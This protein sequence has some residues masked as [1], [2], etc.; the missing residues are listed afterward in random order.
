MGRNRVGPLLTHPH[1]SLAPH[2]D[3]CC[4]WG[5][6][7]LPTH[8]HCSL[9]PQGAP[10][11]P[12]H[13]AR[14]DSDFPWGLTFNIKQAGPDLACELCPFQKGKRADFP[15]SEGSWPSSLLVQETRLFNEGHCRIRASMDTGPPLPSSVRIE[16]RHEW[17]EVPVAVN[18]GVLADL[19]DLTVHIPGLQVCLEVHG[20]CL[21]ATTD[22]CLDFLD[23]FITL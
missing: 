6:R 5:E 3:Q 15:E 17:V 10:Y 21:H 19:P 2:W 8:P 22:Q 23:I 18:E 14:Q 4:L 7:P 11:R 16:G 12:T 13:P 9:A 1:C 20:V